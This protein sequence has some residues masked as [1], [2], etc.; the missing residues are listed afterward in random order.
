MTLVW[1]WLLLINQ[2]SVKH[3]FFFNWAGLFFFFYL[4]LDSV[5]E[6]TWDCETVN[7]KGQSQS[8]APAGFLHMCYL[9]NQV[10]DRSAQDS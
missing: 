2:C 8:H 6:S 1:L 9:L 3:F 4:L 10:S 7:G 5:V